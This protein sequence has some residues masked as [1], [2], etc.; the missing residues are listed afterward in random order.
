MNRLN[1]WQLI[2]QSLQAFW[3]R[4]SNEYLQTLT[5]RS[6]WNTAARELKVGEVVFVQSNPL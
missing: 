4:W 5:P 1:R 3:R 6:K 2:R